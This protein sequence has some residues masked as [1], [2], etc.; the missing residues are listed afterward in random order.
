MARLYSCGTFPCTNKVHSSLREKIISV[1]L[2]VFSY[3]FP[4]EQTAFPQDVKSHRVCLSALSSFTL[5]APSLK[6][7]RRSAL[8]LGYGEQVRGSISSVWTPGSLCLCV[9]CFIGFLIVYSGI[10]L[11]L[12][13]QHAVAWV[14]QFVL[15]HDLLWREVFWHSTPKLRAC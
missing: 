11:P 3:H 4:F 14:V 15:I 6:F 1:S 7:P 13:D 8:F 2:P 10:S 9:H 5:T 12:G